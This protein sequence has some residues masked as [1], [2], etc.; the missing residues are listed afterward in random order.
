[1]CFLLSFGI[2]LRRIP[3]IGWQCVVTLVLVAKS[4]DIG[5]Y[6]FGKKFGKHRLARVVSPKKSVEGA[7]F[8]LLSGAL[9]A[10]VLASIP[11]TR[12]AA[13]PVTIGFSIVVGI[14]AQLGDLAESLIKRDAE[15]KDSSSV[16]PGLGGV[17]DMTDCVLIA[18]PVGYLFVVVCLRTGL[19]QATQS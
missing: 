9:V 13:L 11:A 19:V 12:F 6:F 16:V 4:G 1:V 7:V 8:G 15:V 18:A 17:L 3:D 5:A 2:W 14:A 10:A